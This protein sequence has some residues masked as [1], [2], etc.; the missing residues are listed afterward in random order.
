M[1]QH[2]VGWIKFS[3]PYTLTHRKVLLGLCHVSEAVDFT[4]ILIPLTGFALG[5][6]HSLD[7]D[8][9]VAVSALIC[10]N[11]SLRK[12]IISATAWGAGH[13]IILLLVGLLVLTLRAV[14]PES[15]VALFEFAGGVMLV[16]LGVLVVRPLIAERIS[17]HR[18]GIQDDTHTHLDARLTDSS[19]GHTHLHRSALTGVLQGLGGSAALM[20][21]TLTVV[22]SVELGLV[23]ILVF[24]AGVILGMI[25]IAALVSSLLA[26]TA[27][28]LEKAHKIIKAV[29]GSA[30]IVFGV[31]IIVQVLV[32]L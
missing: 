4:P 8:H 32:K 13:S 22:S 5:L 26:F 17:I 18:N 30:S 19:K 1:A 15:I 7:P 6:G 11:T 29:T 25:G 12:S 21:V 9:V 20:V 2:L 10:N 14:I 31:F 23:L 16:I 3:T 28:R 24:G 27:S